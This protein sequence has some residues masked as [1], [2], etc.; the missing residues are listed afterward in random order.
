[1]RKKNQ[2]E[3]LAQILRIDT[4]KDSA[5]K[6]FRMFATLGIFLKKPGNYKQHNL[7]RSNK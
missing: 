5:V 4:K 7:K 1:M 3:Y 6:L 2:I